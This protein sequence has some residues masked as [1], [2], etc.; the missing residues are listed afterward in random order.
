MSTSETLFWGSAPAAWASPGED[1]VIFG[2]TPT[3]Q[4]ILMGEGPGGGLPPPAPGHGLPCS[5]NREKTVHH[6]SSAG[7]GRPRGGGDE[8]PPL[9]RPTRR[10]IMNRHGAHSASG[11]GATPGA[12]TTA[13]LAWA[14]ILLR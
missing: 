12:A 3:W 4:N 9:E 11:Q 10:L 8:S 7:G 5:P 14:Y 13:P 2:F 6:P 1:G